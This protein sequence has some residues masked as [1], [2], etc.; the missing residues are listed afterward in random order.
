METSARGGR[1]RFH[2]F[3]DVLF[4]QVDD[5][6]DNLSE[7]KL[8]AIRDYVRNKRN[9]MSSE[10][11]KKRLNR[12]GKNIKKAFKKTKSEEPAGVDVTAGM[13][14]R[15]TVSKLQKKYCCQ[16]CLQDS[17]HECSVEHCAL[18][19]IHDEMIVRNIPSLYKLGDDW[20]SR[21]K[22]KDKRDFL[23]RHE[24]GQVA[25]DGDKAKQGLKKSEM[26]DIK[27]LS[28]KMKAMLVQQE[29]LRS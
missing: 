24:L 8:K 22:I 23:K 16:A 7:E 15:V 26:K 18:G 4:E 20:K 11:R 5:A 21:Y 3:L 28:D 27:P 1:R 19:A 14:G 29:Q 6:K 25:Q 10:E 13:G 2:Q 9:K 12:F 17:N